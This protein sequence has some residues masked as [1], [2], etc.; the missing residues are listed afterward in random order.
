[1]TEIN[2]AL[3]EKARQHIGTRAQKCYQNAYAA[4]LEMPELADGLYVEGCAIC[5]GDNV[6]EHG[7]I[8][9]NGRI[10]DPA[11]CDQGNVSYFAGLRFTQRQVRDAIR[12]IPKPTFTEDLPIF[13]RFGGGGCDSPEM[14]RAFAAAWESIGAHDIAQQFLDQI[15]GSEGNGE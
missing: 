6:I 5:N 15:D 4:L 14:M 13:Y 10:V 3:S 7:W 8:E 1:M 9:L 12:T 11:L 2:Q